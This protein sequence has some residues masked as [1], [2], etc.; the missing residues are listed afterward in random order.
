MEWPEPNDGAWVF[1]HTLHVKSTPQRVAASTQQQAQRCLQQ[2][3]ESSNVK[4]FETLSDLLTEF[5]HDLLDGAAASRWYW[6]Q[7]SSLMGEPLGTA[8]AG[9]SPAKARAQAVASSLPPHAIPALSIQLRRVFTAYP[10]QMAAVVEGLFHRGDGPRL[11]QTINEEDARIITVELAHQGGYV[12]VEPHELGAETGVSLPTYSIAPVWKT[13]LSLV[14]ETSTKAHWLHWLIAQ[15]AW[16]LA[17]AQSPTDTLE[18]VKVWWRN[19]RSDLTQSAA[20]TNGQNLSFESNENGLRTTLEKENKS[21]KINNLEYIPRNHLIH[22]TTDQNELPSTPHPQDLPQSTAN[23]GQKTNDQ[24]NLK[25]EQSSLGT[26]LPEALPAKSLTDHESNSNQA[27]PS[28]HPSGTPITD[29]PV[30]N[31]NALLGTHT[32][33][34]Q[35]GGLLYL[36]NVLRRDGLQSMMSDYWSV[37]P[38]G[39]FWLFRLGELLE[40]DQ[41][42]PLTQ[43]VLSQCLAEAEHDA[44]SP[45]THLLPALPE[46]QRLRALLAQWYDPST[47]WNPE[48]LRLPARIVLSSSHIDLFAPL[49]CV[50]VD[51]RLAGLD[52]DPGWL[53]WLGRVVHFY[54]DDDGQFNNG[55]LNHEQFNNRQNGEPQ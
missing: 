5:I 31:D 42:D 37:Y 6:R 25:T 10:D 26:P 38:S 29:A 23:K 15:Q 22:K 45:P 47:L 40:V 36:L 8:Q 21:N 18:A 39:W 17:L 2:R 16:P 52:V 33:H 3:S 49:H 19:N 32:L 27:S 55:Q 34:T 1:V 48:L 53:P 4:R 54:F 20:P 13:A 11:L 44:A 46:A 24:V 50:R 41:N 9:T 30:K 28:Q 35:Q 7:W 14:T 51:V 12:Y 43:F